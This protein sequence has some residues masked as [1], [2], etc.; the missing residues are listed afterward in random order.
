MVTLELSGKYV[1]LRR[2]NSEVMR[3]MSPLA[4]DSKPSRPNVCPRYFSGASLVTKENGSETL[5]VFH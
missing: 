1:G 3:E 5:M 4:L 2:L